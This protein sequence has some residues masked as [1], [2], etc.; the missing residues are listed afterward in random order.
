MK[1]C[2]LSG[3]KEIVGQEEVEIDYTGRLTGLLEILSQRYGE[4][5]R[6]LLLD[7]EA[8]GKKSAFVK[9]LV[10]GEDVAQT[11]PELRGE[12]TVFLFLPI[13]GG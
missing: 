11:D 9:V 4:R 3:L 8:Q 6:M 5:L 10:E 7:P 12:E 1:L 2:F 13:A